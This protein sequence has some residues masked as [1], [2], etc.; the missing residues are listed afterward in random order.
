MTGDLSGK[1]EIDDFA[2]VMNWSDWS[3]KIPRSQ[4]L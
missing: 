1:K 2:K 4:M 3:V